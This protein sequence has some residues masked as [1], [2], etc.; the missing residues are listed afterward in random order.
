MLSSLE[1]AAASHERMRPWWKCPMAV[2]AVHFGRICSR[3][4]NGSQRRIDFDYIL[5]ESTG[6]GEPIPVAQ[7]FTYMDEEQKLI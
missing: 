4:S 3:K 6:V 1:M 7:T 2:S 5:I